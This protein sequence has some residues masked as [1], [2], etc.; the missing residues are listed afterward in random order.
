MTRFAAVL[1][2]R[3]VFRR[4]AVR[5]VLDVAPVLAP[6]RER[7]LD[8][9]ARVVRPLAT[10]AFV[11]F[12]LVFFAGESET[13][14]RFFDARGLLP[15]SESISSTMREPECVVFDVPPLFARVP[16]VVVLFFGMFSLTLR[17][18]R[19]AKRKPCASE[20]VRRRF[21]RR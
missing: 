16:L 6:V 2:A 7:A 5:V 4:A 3:R 20:D 11:R 21:V 17:R 1:P 9:R 10:F 14:T 15:N 13:L 18:E 8:L 19:R 12:E